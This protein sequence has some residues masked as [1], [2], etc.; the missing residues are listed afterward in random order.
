M[1]LIGRFPRGQEQ[2]M[3]PP[4][5]RPSIRFRLVAVAGT[6]LA[7]LAYTRPALAQTAYLRVS[8]VGYESGK[9][10]FR[11]YLMSTAEEGGVNFSVVNSKGA[12]AYSGQV[13]A[14]L[15]TWSHSPKV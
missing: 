3:A 6:L 4:G 14:L 12:S 8:Q 13:G 9:T 5:S 7:L 15:G 1:H 2:P 11:A 10:P